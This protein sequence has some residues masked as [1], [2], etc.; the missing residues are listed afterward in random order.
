[1]KLYV[2]LREQKSIAF[3]GYSSAD[4]SWVVS[5]AC[6][7]FSGQDRPRGLFGVHWS[8]D[9]VVDRWVYSE[10]IPLAGKGEGVG[11]G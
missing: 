8:S 9:V 2:L 10:A 5:A 3:T 11:G 6:E 1:M 7:W 4:I